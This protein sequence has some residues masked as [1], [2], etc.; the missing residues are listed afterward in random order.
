[1][2]GIAHGSHTWRD[3]RNACWHG[4]RLETHA[5]LTADQ[6][7]IRPK[8]PHSKWDQDSRQSKRRSP[9]DTLTAD[10][11][12]P[13]TRSPRV[14][15]CNYDVITG[16]DV[17]RDPDAKASSTSGSWRHSGQPATFPALRRS[18][19]PRWTSDRVVIIPVAP[20]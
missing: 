5:V 14:T 1:M 6:D 15:S 18:S 20:D 17:G 10:G 16:R 2:L 11:N 3:E 12:L 19:H 8:S 13:A 4:T 7:T 9:I